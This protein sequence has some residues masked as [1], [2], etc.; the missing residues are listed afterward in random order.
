[1]EVDY[2]LLRQIVIPQLITAIESTISELK[3]LKTTSQQCVFPVPVDR[4]VGGKLRMSS[5]ARG[6][7]QVRRTQQH[8]SGQ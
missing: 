8:S 6:L 7:N 5:L 1:M 4:F 3:K 2:L